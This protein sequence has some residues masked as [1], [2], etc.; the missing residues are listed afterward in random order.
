[1]LGKGQWQKADEILDAMLKI[2]SM[3]ML[4]IFKWITALAQGHSGQAEENLSTAQ[5]S[6][7]GPQFLFYKA[8]GWFYLGRE[9][10]AKELLGQAIQG[11]LDPRDIY[12]SKPQLA[13]LMPASSGS[14]NI[15][16][17]GGRE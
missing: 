8:L 10:T 9:D 3:P 4:H 6:L 17:T 12:L 16:T 11:G 15:Y 13:G 5:K 1:L 7:G 14:E 2:E